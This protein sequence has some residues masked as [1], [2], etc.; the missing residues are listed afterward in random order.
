MTESGRAVVAHHSMLVV[1][2]LGV[3][4]FDVGKA[5]EQVG[6][7]ASRVV[8]NLFETFREVSR[9]NVLESYHDALEYKEEALQ[10]FN[11]GNLSLSE[12]V[13]A[14]D[15]FWGVCQKLLKMV[16]DMREVPEELEGSKRALSDTYFCNFSMFQSLPD[17]WAIDQCCSPSCRFTASV[18][19]RPGARSWPTSPVTPTAARSITSS[20]AAT[21][22][23]CSSCTRSTTARTTTSASS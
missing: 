1:D 2:I 9:K 17:I 7:E 12:R 19:S 11:L 21:L 23:R 10:L 5:P 4:E 6:N 22:N 8:K 3:G 15:I 18:K 13:V 16:R 14:E 20:I